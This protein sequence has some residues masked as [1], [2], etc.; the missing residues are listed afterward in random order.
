MI[1]EGIIFITFEPSGTDTDSQQVQEDS[2]QALK[3]LN[4]HL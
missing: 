2:K 3:Q 1:N 4:K